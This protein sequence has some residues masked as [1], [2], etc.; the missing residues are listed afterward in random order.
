MNDDLQKKSGIARFPLL[1]ASKAHPGAI[2]R[3]IGVTMGSAYGGG[4]LIQ[5]FVLSYGT[6]E[7]K[8]DK[9]VLLWAIGVVAAFELVTIP[10]WG[11]FRTRLAVEW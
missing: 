7:L 3:I 4:C 11:G 6:S 8:I 10:F 5:P 1:K 2:L 9:S